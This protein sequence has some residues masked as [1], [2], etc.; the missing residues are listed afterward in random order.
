MRPKHSKSISV[1][2]THCLR[3][4]FSLTSHYPLTLA[5]R[6]RISLRLVMETPH[7]H[8]LHMA[9]SNMALDCIAM[10][11]KTDAGHEGNYDDVDDDD[12][13]LKPATGPE[14]APSNQSILDDPLITQPFALRVVLN[15]TL[16]PAMMMY[17]Q[18]HTPNPYSNTS[19]GLP[20]TVFHLTMWLQKDWRTI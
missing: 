6:I 20:H 18:G 4:L 17:G 7:S 8:I 16:L 9:Q 10:T 19:L 15:L 2:H 12:D 1:R 13:A 11:S 5:C 14:W 3:W